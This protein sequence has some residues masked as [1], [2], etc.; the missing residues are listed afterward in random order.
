MSDQDPL[1]SWP[2]LAGLPRTLPTAL[3]CELGVLGKA[4]GDA[5]DF[6]WIAAGAGFSGPTSDLARHLGLGSEDVM[7]ATLLWRSDANLYQAVHCY[8][9]RAPDT[10]GR[11]FLEKQVL[12]W[13]RPD[14]LP[15]VLGA[16]ILLP[17][18]A[19]VDDSVWQGR[20][21]DPFAEH[22]FVTLGVDQV[23]RPTVDPV[24][25]LRTIRAGTA[26]LRRRF[27][28]A[29]LGVL[30]ARLLAGQRGCFP[31]QPLEPLGP[32]AL[33]ALLLPLPRVIADRA[34]L[35]AWLPSTSPAPET[36]RQHW[37]LIL[38]SD[39]SLPPPAAVDPVT[40]AA[41]DAGILAQGSAM[42]A[43][44]F[45]DDPR[46]LARTTV[47]RSSGA[48]GGSAPEPTRL[49]LWGP[50]GSGKTV[51]LGQL[52]WQLSGADGGDW[53]IY[54]GDS[55]LDFFEMMRD[56]LYS[57]N[58]FPPGTALGT[59]LNLVCRLRHRHTGEQVTLALEDRAG[60]DYEALHSEVL[61]RL[62]QADGIILLLDP[63]RRDDRVFNEVSHTF[64]RTLLAAGQG[65][66]SGGPAGQDPR[67]VAVCVTKADEL[68]AT[69]EDYRMALREPAEFAA[70][71]LD[72]RLLNYLESRFARFALFPVSAAGVRMQHGAIEPVFFYDEALRP[73]INS[74]PPFNLMAPIDWLIREL[75]S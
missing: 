17:L 65:S 63:N 30:Y 10:Q 21:R 27:R 24:L 58:A 48:S 15:A 60:A 7:R 41:P 16:L 57:R 20:E 52:Y 1:S 9:G 8:P 34:S 18:A 4:P 13:Q 72:A 3:R 12:E 68:I 5:A 55:G 44:I 42:A 28:E 45:R 35:I 2:A 6:H 11:P 32:A 36:L 62:L 43:A 38:G 37:D 56:T 74:G 33:A 71:H 66:A 14:D 26:E 59:S 64:E 67:P 29:D 51:F 50:S 53:D 19:T 61:E 49:T 23:P 75:R 54:P 31:P 69:P 70:A 73:R 39:G 25:L 47:P 40:G 46:D 22:L